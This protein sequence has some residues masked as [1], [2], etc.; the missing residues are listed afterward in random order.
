ML[1]VRAFTP[2]DYSLA[3]DWWRARKAPVI[4]PDHLPPNGFVVEACG[5]PIC[6]SFLYKTD[7]KVACLEGLISAPT[8]D[9]TLR[10]QAIDLLVTASEACAEET[11]HSLAFIFVSE[12][13]SL[14]SHLARNGY[15]PARS[16]VQLIKKLK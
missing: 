11:G 16:I 7:A 2:A 12:H 4:P 5:Q 8:S 15:K 10:Q 14:Q 3:F 9:K 1:N 6:M 13:P